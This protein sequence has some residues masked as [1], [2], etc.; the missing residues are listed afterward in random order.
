MRK[1]LRLAGLATYVTYYTTSED[2]LVLEEENIVLII[3]YVHAFIGKASVI[4]SAKGKIIVLSS[5]RS[6]H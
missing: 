5:I 3:G 4:N 6:S 1:Q 2:H